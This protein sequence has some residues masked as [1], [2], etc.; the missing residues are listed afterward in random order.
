MGYAAV[1]LFVAMATGSDF[2]VATVLIIFLGIYL[3]WRS[4]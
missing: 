1:C 2:P 4:T 3:A